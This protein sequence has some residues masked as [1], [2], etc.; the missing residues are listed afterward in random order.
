ML[1]RHSM[2]WDATEGTR[3]KFT[4]TTADQTVKFAKDN[5]QLIRGHTCIWHSQLPSWVSQI[6]DKATL[7]TVIQDHVQGVMGHFK[8]QVYAF[9]VVN[10][11]FDVR[12]FP[13]KLSWMCSVLT[14]YRK[15]VVSAPACSTTSWART[16]VRNRNSN[17][18][19]PQLIQIVRIAFEAAK[20]ADPDAKRYINDYNLDTAS[21]AKTQG[22][23]KNV[24]KW[25]AAGV[26]I[27]G[28]GSQTHLTAG[29]GANSVAAMAALCAAAP[30]CA[31]TEVDIQNASSSDWA[32]V[33]KACLQQKNCVGITAWGVRDQDSWR[34]QGNPL[35]FDSSFKPKAAYTQLLNAINGS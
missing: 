1:T 29:Q 6:R 34:P 27:D 26:P 14:R 7:T 3:G 9:D 10:E 33:A 17:S 24:K 13:S 28:I 25:I 16:L 15:M 4:L 32:N 8:G 11:I 2:K 20:K 18:R 31:M 30:E 22:I 12:E 21:Y 5:G 19:D 35:L 23:I